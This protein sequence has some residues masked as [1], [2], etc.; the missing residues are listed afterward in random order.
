M[1]PVGASVIIQLFETQIPIRSLSTE[2]VYL[3]ISFVITALVRVHITGED[4]LRGDTRI[5]DKSEW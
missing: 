5:R 3:V 1:P 2:T 4:V